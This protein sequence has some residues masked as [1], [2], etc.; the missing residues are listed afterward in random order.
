MFLFTLSTSDIIT[1]RGCLYLRSY[2]HKTKLLCDAIFHSHTTSNLYGNVHIHHKNVI[3]YNNIKYASI[4]LVLI[5][6]MHIVKHSRS[7]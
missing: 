1:V 6:S 5:R 4:G 2:I 7:Q 3:L